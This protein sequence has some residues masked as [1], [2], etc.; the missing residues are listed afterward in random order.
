MPG[1][2]FPSPA[3]FLTAAAALAA[4]PAALGQNPIVRVSVA[5]GGVEA[6]GPSFYPSVSADGRFVAFTSDAAN[7]VP[8]D[9]NG[10]SDVFRHDRV[11]GTTIRVSVAGGS[12]ANDES[13]TSYLT[14]ISA[15]G[16][17]VVFSSDATN[18]VAND[19]NGLEDVFVHDVVA[20]TT[21]RV[22]VGPGGVEADGVSDDASISEDGTRVVFVSGATNLVSPGPAIQSQV[23]VR[24]LAA[25][26]T[27]LASANAAGQAG[28]SSANY[29]A[30]S[31]DGRVVAFLS[32]SH[33]LVPGVP[34]WAVPYAFYVKDLPTGAIALGVSDPAVLEGRRFAG[35][36]SLSRDGSL[37]AFWSDAP[38]LVPGDTNGAGDA[39]VLDRAAATVR[40]VS[41][42]TSGTEGDALI[43]FPRMSPD[44][45]F[46]AFSS[47]FPNLVAG[48]TNGAADIF[49]QDRASPA[50]APYC[51]S[52]TDSAG[53]TPA[54]T[55]IGTP[56]PSSPFGF[57]VVGMGTRDHRMGVLQ[58]SL[59]PTQVR[60]GGGLRC[61]AAPVRT[62]GRTNS[63]GTAGGGC[64]GALSID[65]NPLIRAGTDPA[66][67]PGTVVYA[68][69]Y[70][71]DAQ[72]PTGHG[73]GIT[74]GVRFVIE[75]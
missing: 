39:F 13:Y 33:N 29:P 49:V 36:Q 1:S 24:D 26:Q 69:Y 27:I 9:T 28:D 22:S 75:P 38:G 23:Y 40:R 37:V 63:G 2:R 74:E 60:F 53:C 62:A 35:Y 68:Q 57:L 45:R 17:Y 70:Y 42:A 72:D 15:D 73:V 71:R 10:V 25:A 7:L 41:V 4:A 52:K 11:T 56:S 18:L 59:G 12:E 19:T 32:A 8:G 34:G 44:G 58:Y 3:R 31:G 20:G 6:D 47:V 48:D 65:F 46:V 21:S 5:S 64:T 54:V 30:I 43:A 61:I 14:A 50:P 67:I 16:R 55:W 66:L 51:R